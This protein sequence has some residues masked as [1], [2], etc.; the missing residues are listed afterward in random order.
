MREWQVGD[1]I[2]DG[3]DIGVPDIPYM[4]YL[5]DDDDESSKEDIVDNFKQYINNARDYYNM[6]HYEDAFY[7]LDYSFRTYGKMNDFEKTQVRTDPFNQEWIIELCCKIINNHGEYYHE[8]TEFLIKNQYKLN[9]C[10]DCDCVYPIDYNCCIKCGK[11]LTKPY[12]KSPEQLVEEIPNVLS[13]RVYD[14]ITIAGLVNRSLVLMKSNDCRLVE[15]KDS[16]YG[17]DF[18]FEK[19]HKYF[20]TRYI[21]EYVPGS[22]RVFED[23]GVIHNHDK[24][25]M[26]ESFKKLIKDT[27]NKTGFVFKEY[28]G[29]YGSQLDDNRFDF[30]FNDEIH[31]IARFDMGDGE[32]AVYDVDLDNMEFSEDYRVY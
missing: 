28:D 23:F 18:I 24:L 27:E 19:E 13:G 21:C 26:N 11:P 8:A 5:K 25:L 30:I 4:G 31:V 22:V 17:I 9:L 29:G 6:Q 10:M 15:I 32:I 14:D 16:N 12:V 3:N 1:P 7:Y 20:K 2:G